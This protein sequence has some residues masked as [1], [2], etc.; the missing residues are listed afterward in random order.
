LL[1]YIGGDALGLPWEGRPPEEVRLDELEAL[2]EREAWPSGS[3]SDDT[4]LTLLVAEHLA[5]SGGLGDPLQ[6]LAQLVSRSESIPGL[7]PSTTRAIA[8]FRATGTPDSS[9]SDTNGAPMRALPLG[10]ALPPAADDRRREW[11]QALTRMTHTGR[12]AVTAACVMAACASWAIEGAPPSLLVEV[13]ADEAVVVGRDTEVATALGALRRGR[14]S[15]PSQGISLAPGETVA[16]VLHCCRATDG[17]LVAGLRSAVGLGGDT[18]T[19][20]ALVGGLLGCRL[21]PDDV[22]GRLGWLD[23]VNLPSPEQLSRLASAL[24]A[25]RLR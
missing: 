11:T 3:T 23:R 19:V 18:D 15:P 21:A 10:W 20:A 14:W 6:F 4:A 2:P 9:G 1:A 17:D 16:A 5:R 13:A 7:G 12:D 8:H 24:T 25:L 22:A